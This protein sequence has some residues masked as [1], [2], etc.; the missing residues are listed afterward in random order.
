MS[1]MVSSTELAGFNSKL[2]TAF[3]LTPDETVLQKKGCGHLIH[4]S[5]FINEETGRLFI[6]N[7]NGSSSI[8]KENDARKIIYPGSAGDPR[9]DTAQ[10]L[11]QMQTRAIP[12]FEKAYPNT[13]ALF[14]FD[15]SSTHASLGP[16]ALHAIDM[17]KSNGGKQ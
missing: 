8:P 2:I 5:D 17:N 15:Q 7:A 4:V 16:D 11:E 9:W 14:I 10:L 3:R 1:S 12:I 13:Q 6:P